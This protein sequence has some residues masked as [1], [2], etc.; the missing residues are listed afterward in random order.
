LRGL[1]EK[2]ELAE[3]VADDLYDYTP[4][5]RE[6]KGIQ[7]LPHDLY[8]AVQKAHNSELL[9]DTLGDDVLDTLIETK[10]HEYDSYRLHVSQREIEES[11]NL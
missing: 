3:P 10:L 6:Q 5:E 1:E 4:M 7:S 11:I 8:A 9:R 2:Y